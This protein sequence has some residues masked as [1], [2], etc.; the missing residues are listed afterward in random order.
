MNLSN[1]QALQTTGIHIIS[2]LGF[3]VILF[4]VLIFLLVVFKQIRSMNKIVTQDDLFPYLEIF[5]L[6][7]I[8]GVIVLFLVS[9]VIL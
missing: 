7:L 5:T 6:F 2:K 1:W 9:I 8:G 3:L 4:F